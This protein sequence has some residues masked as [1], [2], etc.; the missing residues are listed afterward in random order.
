MTI[1]KIALFE[2]TKALWPEVVQVS[3]NPNAT[4]DIYRAN[5]GA[6]SLDDDWRQLAIWSFHQALAHHERQAL[7]KGVPLHPN[8]V[9][10]DEFDAWMRAN[11]NGHDCW[12]EERAEYERS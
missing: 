3:D 11:L 6:F 12:L 4:Y 1:D 5:E 8:G 2:I 10:F 7:A 9:T